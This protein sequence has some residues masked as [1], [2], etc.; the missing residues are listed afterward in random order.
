MRAASGGIDDI[1]DSSEAC[2]GD[3]VRGPV[4]GVGDM[5]RDSHAGTGEFTG[6]VIDSVAR[7]VVPDM[8]ASGRL[9]GSERSW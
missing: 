1:V 3:G 4:D 2:L 5:S 7:G 8:A 6:C 9:V